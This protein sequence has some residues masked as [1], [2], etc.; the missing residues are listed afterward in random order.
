[1]LVRLLRPQNEPLLPQWWTQQW[2]A[3][4]FDWMAEDN[5]QLI[6][7]ASSLVS[8]KA[9]SLT[10]RCL[11]TRWMFF[12][13]FS[14]QILK[15]SPKAFPL[16]WIVSWKTLILEKYLCCILHIQPHSHPLCTISYQIQWSHSRKV[17]NIYPLTCAVPDSPINGPLTGK[18]VSHKAVVFNWDHNC[19]KMLLQVKSFENA[20]SP[21]FVW[22]PQL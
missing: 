9:Q 15:F 8:L 6:T 5:L 14:L 21:M 18:Q 2:I 22:M 11:M 19:L 10:S 4:P 7:S 3:I 12:W 20:A 17:E 13:S 1:M 16:R